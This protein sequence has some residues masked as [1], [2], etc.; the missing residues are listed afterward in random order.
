MANKIADVLATLDK[1]SE[2]IQ[3]QIQVK[4]GGT[5]IPRPTAGWSNTNEADKA[6]IGDCLEVCKSLGSVKVP[7]A[8]GLTKVSHFTYADLASNGRVFKAI[9]TEVMRR[10]A[11]LVIASKQS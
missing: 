10:Y 7:G 1:E 9:Q 6:F 8:P 3:S 5:S 2:K 11:L 4:T